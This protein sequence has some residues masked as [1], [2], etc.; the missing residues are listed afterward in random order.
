[1][2]LVGREVVPNTLLLISRVVLG[3]LTIYEE[4]TSPPSAF[5]SLWD[6]RGT[7]VSHAR[8]DVIEASVCEYGVPI[9]CDVSC[10]S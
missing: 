6:E 5:L 1:M 3:G 8:W 9:R 2:G 7:G 10:M 4:R